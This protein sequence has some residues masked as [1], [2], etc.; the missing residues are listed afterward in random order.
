MLNFTNTNQSLQTVSNFTPPSQGT[1]TG[2]Y[3]TTTNSFQILFRTSTSFD[4][5]VGATG[6]NITFRTRLMRQG[7]KETRSTLLNTNTLYHAAFSWNSTGDNWIY[8]NGVLNITENQSSNIATSG[9]LKVGDTGGQTIQGRVEDFRFYNRIL[10]A[11]EILTIYSCNGTDSIY[12]GLINRWL[13]CDGFVGQVPS[14]IIDYA[15]SGINCQVNNSPSFT[16]SNLTLRKN[17]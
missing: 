17:V 15:E 9:V 13:M 1:F 11:D 4:V 3:F 14:T 6:L 5:T 16:D 8:I 2:W 7:S 10:T 12:H